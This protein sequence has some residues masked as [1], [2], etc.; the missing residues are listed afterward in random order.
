MPEHQRAIVDPEI[1]FRDRLRHIGWTIWGGA[2]AIGTGLVL[3]PVL[4][5]GLAHGHVRGDLLGGGVAVLGA[6]LVLGLCPLQRSRGIGWVSAVTMCAVIGVA[7]G[8]IWLI[9]PK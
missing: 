4:F 8:A 5:P 6:G 9:F 1:R 2:F 7:I 3:T